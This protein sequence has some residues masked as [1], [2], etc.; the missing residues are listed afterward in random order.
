M[1]FYDEII[2]VGNFKVKID[3]TDTTPG[4]LIDKILAGTNITITENN[5][6]GNETL[7]INSSGGGGVTL[8]NITGGT[9]NDTNKA[10]TFVSQPTLVNINGAFYPPTGGAITWSYLTGTVTLSSPVGTGGEIYGIK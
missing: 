4:Y 10:F 8:L 9:I 3:S 5:I 6:G 2:C 1:A 7:T